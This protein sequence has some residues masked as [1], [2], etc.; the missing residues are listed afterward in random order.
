MK[1]NADR[2]FIYILARVDE[3]KKQLQS[4]YKLT[5]EDL[6]EIT[7]DWSVD[8]LISADPMEIFDIDSPKATHDTP[9][10]NKTK[11]NEEAQ[12]VSSTL[13]KT[14]SISPKQGGDGGQIDGAKVEKK[15]GEVTLPRDKEDLSKKRKV[16]PPKP[17]SQ[18]QSK[19]YMTKMQTTLTSDNFDF[20]VTTLNNASLEIVEKLEAK[21][22]EI[23]N[24]IK[25]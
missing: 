21:H 3:H 1:F 23:Y 25:V 11:K 15:K 19:A 10:P 20:I 22:E 4:Y 9:G 12:D 18:K 13:A 17:S 2:H 8:L 6:E 7:K 16:S 24:Q 5:E 14:A